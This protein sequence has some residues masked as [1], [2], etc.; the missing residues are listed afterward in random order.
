MGKVND[1]PTR[2]PTVGGL[3]VPPCPRCGEHRLQLRSDSWWCS[4]CGAWDDRPFDVSEGGAGG[5]EA[6]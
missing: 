4:G 5:G 2:E 3:G 6:P 1:D